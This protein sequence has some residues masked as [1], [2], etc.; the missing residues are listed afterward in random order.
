M[1]YLADDWKL[2]TDLLNGKMLFVTTRTNA[3]E[4]TTT[5]CRLVTELISNHQEADTQMLLHAEH[6]SYAYEGV[7]IATPDTDV[8]LIALS[9]VSSINAHVN[10]LT[11]TNEKRCLI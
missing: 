6:A 5:A 9:H 2:N 10:M 1:S 3:F 8:F 11:G 4:I 7:I